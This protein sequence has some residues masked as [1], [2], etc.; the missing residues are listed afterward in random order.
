M[1]GAPTLTISVPQRIDRAEAG[2]AKRRVKPTM[3]IRVADTLFIIATSNPKGRL[4]VQ[5]SGH[6]AKTIKENLSSPY[7]LRLRPYALNLFCP[8][9]VST[10]TWP[11]GLGY[12]YSNR[13]H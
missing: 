6:K 5:G 1:V 9:S 2:T 13:H 3:A 12:R 8:Q 11:N 4:K 7:A 10:L